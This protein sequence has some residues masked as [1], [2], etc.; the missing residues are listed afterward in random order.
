MFPSKNALAWGKRLDRFDRADVTITQFC[1]QEG[2][3][4]ASFY[5]WRRKL[6][7]QPAS[8]PRNQDP[9]VP[10]FLPVSLTGK[11]AAPTPPASTP[12]SR[13]T[14]DLPGGIRI[15]FELPAGHLHADQAEARP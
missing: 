3:S 12:P 1:R 10:R 6:R 13:M 5:H 14:I 4:Q 2:V 7:S 8:L 11:P 9:P 15:Q